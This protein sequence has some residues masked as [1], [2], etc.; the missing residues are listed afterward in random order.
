MTDY[1][2]PSADV[3]R[4]AVTV[5]GAGQATVNHGVMAL[6]V[7]LANGDTVAL[8]KLP[9]GH[10]PVDFIVDAD[11]LDSGAEAALVFDVGVLGEGEDPDAFITGSEIGQAGGVARLSNVAGRRLEAVEYDRLVGITVTTA[12][13]TGQ[14]GT[15]AGTLISRPA[16]RDD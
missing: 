4:P 16:G 14:A 11:D 8:A 5:T 12:P 13:A 15:I 2:A 3:Q 10:V 6:A 7:A 1:V 9:A